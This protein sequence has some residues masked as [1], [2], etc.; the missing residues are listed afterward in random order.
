MAVYDEY[1]KAQGDE[2]GGDKSTAK[3]E[4]PEEKA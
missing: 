2:E 4:K 1:L 3:E